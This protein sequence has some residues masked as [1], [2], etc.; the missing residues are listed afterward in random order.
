MA[1]LLSG[2]ANNSATIRARPLKAASTRL[3]STTVTDGRTGRPQF[4]RRHERDSD[5]HQLVPNSSGSWHSA[6][7][8]T[9]GGVPNANNVAVVFGT[10]ITS[11][12]VVYTESNVT[13]KSIRFDNN[14]KYAIA[15]VG[16]VT[17]S[18]NSGNASIQVARGAQEFQTPV[19]LAS[20]TDVNVLTGSLSFNNV[21]NLGG[22]TLHVQSG[23]VNINNSVIPGAAVRSLNGDS[24]GAAA[25]AQPGWRLH[26]HWNAERRYRRHQSWRVH[27][28]QLQWYG[29]LGWIH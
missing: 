25:P 3:P 6:A 15:G 5:H 8:W 17:L 29:H 19:T 23:T 2:S 20:D 27:R 26:E 22:K 24:L 18:S 13:A 14:S 16:T 12:K 9:T 10:A 4:R 1:L 7:N 28:V 21:L 11:G